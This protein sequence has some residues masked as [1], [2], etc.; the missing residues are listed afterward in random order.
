MENNEVKSSG[1]AKASLV[2][3]IIAMCTCFIPIVNNASFV[4][5]LLATIFGLITLFKKGKKGKAIAG[6]ILGVLSIIITLALQSS[7]SKAIDDFSNDL[8]NLTG[9]NT[10]EVLKNNV[11]VKLGE[12][13]VTDQGYGFFD[14]E[15]AVTVTNKSNER[16]SFSVEIEAIAADGTRLNTDTVYISNLGPGQS[17]TEKAFVIITSDQVESYKS[18]TFNVVEA[19]MY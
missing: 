2:L 12:F 8:D 18:A 1:M 13:V 14:T 9:E 10:E 4:L 5:G 11:D 3:G 19:S 16:K 15:L 7:W 17:Q 6:L